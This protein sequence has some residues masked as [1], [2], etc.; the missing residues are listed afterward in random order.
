MYYNNRKQLRR[1]GVNEK[2]KCKEELT[3]VIDF[4]THVFPDHIAKRT[5]E[6]LEAAGNV[7]AFTGGT[8]KELKGSMKDNHI[9]LSV[10]LP[11]VTRP[12]QFESIHQFA[13]EIHG[14][15]GILSFGGVHPDSDNYL[16][17][18]RK[19]KSLGLPGIKLHPDYQ[20]TFVDDP[21]ILNI[22]Q[23]AV[24]LDLIVLLHA[25]I[26]IG[27][28]EPVHC[29]PKRAANMLEQINTD[30]AKIVLAHTGGYDQWDEVEE[31][32]V[33]KN[34]W[35]DISYSM[36]RIKEDQ[37]MR[38]IRNHGIERILFASDS[39]WGGQ[40]ETLEWVK[41]MDLTDE[42]LEK[43]FCKNGLELLG[44]KPQDAEAIISR[45]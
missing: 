3:L 38:I 5:M 22:I 29:P 39:P 40:K 36:N 18:L 33:G 8:L 28:P 11:V 41:S 1:R 20:G 27:L 2:S 43:I 13:T 35:L 45:A 34:V 44:L 21:K 17:E 25:G 32:L 7:K 9:A 26:D 31:Y 24:E 14:K 6:K 37:F 12:A 16:E 23:Y 15:E 4:H 30:K 19:I 10:V 42:E